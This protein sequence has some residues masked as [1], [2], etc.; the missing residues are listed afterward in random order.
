MILNDGQYEALKESLD[1]MSASIA[2][3]DDSVSI[4]RDWLATQGIATLKG[5]AS[6]M[7]QD[8]E[9]YHLL[10]SGKFVPPT[11]FRIC[12]LP[13]ILIQTRIACGLTQHELADALSI[14]YSRMKKYEEEEYCGASFSKLLEIADKLNIDISQ[15]LR[16]WGD[17]NDSG[18]VLKRAEEFDWNEFPV[19]EAIKRGWIENS[20][21]SSAT[22][23]FKAWISKVTGPYGTFAY[24]RRTVTDQERSGQGSL[25]QASLFAWQARVLQLAEQTIRESPVNEFRL[26]DRWLG[27]LARQIGY[28]DGPIRA[29]DFLRNHGIVLIIEKHLPQTF[30]DGAA[31]LSHDGIPVVA[32]T[33]RH[34][35]LDYFLFTLFHELGHVFCHLFDR[36][37]FNFCYFDQY[38]SLDHHNAGGSK[39]FSGDEL[40][41]Q[42][43]KF[44]LEKLLPLDS[45]DT[46]R[47]K[48]VGSEDS[49]KANVES[50]EVHSSIIAHNRF[51]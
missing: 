51:D 14:D 44:A 32:L 27:E 40:E 36:T 11:S 22:D 26:D 33:L 43:N 16:S 29:V 21:G 47:S 48:F 6:D 2:K 13:K 25:N 46:C 5:F 1:E 12:E 41:V 15:C 18:T 24:R 8:I 17:Y 19:E 4:E 20:D 45:W 9:E 23:S 49:A 37:N 3:F 38:Y 50:L 34:D 31:M 30:L 35:R 39:I 28:E 7:Q 42:A 10:T